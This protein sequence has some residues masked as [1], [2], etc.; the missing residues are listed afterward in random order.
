M[1]SA[2]N[3]LVRSL[4]MG[5]STNNINTNS[6]RQSEINLNSKLSQDELVLIV[7]EQDNPVRSASRREM[8]SI[9]NIRLHY[10]EVKQSM[11]QIDLNLCD[12]WKERICCIEA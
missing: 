10:I 7:D 5:F 1:K 3:L 2:K 12:Y 8:V 6:G 9:T 11:A 4:R